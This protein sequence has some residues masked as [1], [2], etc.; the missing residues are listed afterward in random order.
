M[1]ATDDGRRC[2]L[3]PG[4]IALHETVALGLY[5][6]DLIDRTTGK[7]K[8]E[9]LKTEV[10]MKQVHT[11]LCGESTGL[12]VARL[13]GATSDEELRSTIKEVASRPK[14]DGEPR[15]IFGYAT[16][17]VQWLDEHSATVLDDG[18]LGFTCHAVVRTE[19]SRGEVRKLREDLIAELNKN[20]R[21]W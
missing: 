20:V 6:P 19:M 3:S 10:L 8:K 13:L 14:K 16:V 5:S 9:A 2:P 18:K 1:K 7:V 4:P 12:S 17:A 15:S 11:D 21:P